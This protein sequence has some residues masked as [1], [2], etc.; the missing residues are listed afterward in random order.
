[1]GKFWKQLSEEQCIDSRDQVFRDAALSRFRN[2][3]WFGSERFLMGDLMHHWGR[4]F[5]DNSWSIRGD[6]MPRSVALPT[7]IIHCVDR[8]FLFPPELIA[9]SGKGIVGVFLISNVLGVRMGKMRRLT[10]GRHSE[11]IRKDA[12]HA[13]INWKIRAPLSLLLLYPTAIY[14]YR[15]CS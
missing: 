15:I 2:F 1:M 6:T 9:L 13:R 4:S 5:S 8:A 3:D 10:D 7:N 12:S 14:Y 11:F